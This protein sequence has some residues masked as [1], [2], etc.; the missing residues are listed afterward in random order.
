MANENEVLPPAQEPEQPRE[1]LVLDWDDEVRYAYRLI[2]TGKDDDGQELNV[3][4]M[5]QPYY[6]GMIAAQMLVAERLAALTDAL[7]ESRS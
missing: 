2:L 5:T 6:M 3:M 4:D 1:E 7:L